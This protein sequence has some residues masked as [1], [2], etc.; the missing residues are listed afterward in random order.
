[1]WYDPAAPAAE[2][3]RI[4]DFYAQDVGEVAAGQ[5]RVIVA[6]YDYEASEGAGQLPAGSQMALVSWHRLQTCAEPSLAVA[7]DF[8]SRYSFPAALE[9]EYGGEAPEPGAQ[10]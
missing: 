10:M 7:L 5:D 2:I 8:T 9:Q 1:M 4:K 6:P 3:R